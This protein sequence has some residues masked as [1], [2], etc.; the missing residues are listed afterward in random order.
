MVRQGPETWGRHLLRAAYRGVSEDRSVGRRVGCGVHV[1][2]G[3]LSD[4][5]LAPG[6]PQA[7]EE[8]TGGRRRRWVS[9]PRSNLL[10]DGCEVG[11][12]ARASAL[13]RWL[14]TGVP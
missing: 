2:S 4:V 13:D 3:R 5:A 12:E 11:K 7:L 10:S 14:R 6:L 9:Y 1:G 8:A